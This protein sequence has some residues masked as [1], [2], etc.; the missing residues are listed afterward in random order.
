MGTEMSEVEMLLYLRR[1]AD[2]LAVR[3]AEAD[4][5]GRTSSWD[6]GEMLALR[7]AITRLER[8]RAAN[9]EPDQYSP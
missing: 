1:R 4:A 5:K 6:R 9:P 7:Q 8:A 3:V 2:Y